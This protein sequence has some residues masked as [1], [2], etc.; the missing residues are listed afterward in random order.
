MAFSSVS[1][2]QAV[3]PPP[4]PTD[5]GPSLAVTMKFIQDMMNNHGTVGY[6]WTRSN[7]NGVAFRYYYTMSEVVADGQN[8]TLSKH[9]TTNTMIEPAQGYNYNENGHAVTG[10]DLSRRDVEIS[11]MSLKAVENIR[12]ET[13]QDAQNRSWAESAHPEVT[14]SITPTVYYLTLV[15][16]RPAFSFHAAFTKGKQQPIVA[17]TSGKEDMLTF[18][19][20]ETANRLAKAL[21][22]AVELCGGGNKDPF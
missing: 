10:D 4:K 13:I 17:D 11:T 8:C 14:V 18:R 12:V 20:E 7:L 5:S 16:S 1:A 15:S 19:D 3:A 9:E 21:L 6:V 22:H 2:Q